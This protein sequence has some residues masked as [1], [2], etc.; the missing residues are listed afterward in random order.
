MIINIPSINILYCNSESPK[1]SGILLVKNKVS[2]M[3]PETLCYGKLMVKNGSFAPLNDIFIFP[4]IFHLGDVLELLGLN[5][6]GGVLGL[7]PGG[8]VLGLNLGGDVLGLNLGGGVLGLNL[9][10][11]VLGLNLG[12]DV[13]GLN[14]GR[15]SIKTTKHKYKY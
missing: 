5:L 3:L 11:G 9:G 14:L 2:S 15:P 13:L 1:L 6:G 4:V 8:G 12:G 10:G 7:N